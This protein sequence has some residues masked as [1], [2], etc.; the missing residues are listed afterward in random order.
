MNNKMNS[1]T[2]PYNYNSIWN[3]PIDKNAKTVEAGFVPAPAFHFDFECFIKAQPDDTAYEVNVNGENVTVKIPDTDFNNCEYACV[4]QPD[5]LSV[6]Q[7][8]NAKIADGELSFDEIFIDNLSDDGV[9]GVHLASGIS[10]MGGAIRKGELLSDEPINHALKVRISSN[11]FLYYNGEEIPGYRYPAKRT[12]SYAVNSVKERI[13]Y[14]GVNKHVVQGTLFT[15]PKDLT[16]EA[17]GLKSKMGKK[18]FYAIQN[19]GAYVV[20]SQAIHSIGFFCEYDVKQE[21]TDTIKM[22]TEGWSK[23]CVLANERAY[24]YDLNHIFENMLAIANTSLL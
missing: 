20:D 1:W 21:L 17:I 22:R 2:S 4:L 6:V 11:R 10:A 15:L 24:V 14:S 16:P 5:G 12:D 23:D 9:E 13:R 8:R 3:T 7:L 18:I 19:Y